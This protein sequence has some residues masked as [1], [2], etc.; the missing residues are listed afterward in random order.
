M[1]FAASLI[2]NLTRAQSQTND[3][4]ERRLQKLTAPTQ[5]PRRG[6]PVQVP[7]AFRFSRATA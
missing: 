5:R 7:S 3:A 4:F 2:A 1:K 6:Q